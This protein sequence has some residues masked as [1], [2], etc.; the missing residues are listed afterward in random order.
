[1]A[2]A[3]HR[4]RLVNELLQVLLWAIVVNILT[5]VMGLLRKPTQQADDHPMRWLFGAALAAVMAVRFAM[6]VE[7]YSEVVL[8]VT[9]LGPLVVLRPAE[10]EED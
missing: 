5:Y 9:I 1:M 8:A 3:D 2:N 6:T 7:D 10:G 4:Q